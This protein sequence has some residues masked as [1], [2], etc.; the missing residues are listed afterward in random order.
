MV[1]CMYTQIYIIYTHTQSHNRKIIHLDY[2]VVL[3]L[4]THTRDISFL[5]VSTFRCLSEECRNI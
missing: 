4:R 5:Q 3:L 2:Y 1:Y